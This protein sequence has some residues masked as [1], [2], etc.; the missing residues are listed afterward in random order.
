MGQGKG[1]ATYKGDRDVYLA[2]FTAQYLNGA[3]NLR[4]IDLSNYII[5]IPI[6]AP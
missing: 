6:A 5:M 4:Q 1:K 3:I 2:F